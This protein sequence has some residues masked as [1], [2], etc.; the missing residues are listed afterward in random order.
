MTLPVAHAVSS[1]PCAQL[2]VV[3][4]QPPR[5][6]QRESHMGVGPV[7]PPAS[8]PASGFAPDDWQDPDTQI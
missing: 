1:D 3:S 2:P 5:K 7:G 8:W 4:Q 6:A